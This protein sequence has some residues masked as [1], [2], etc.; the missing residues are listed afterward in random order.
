[1]KTLK[2]HHVSCTPITH[3]SLTITFPDVI[4]TGDGKLLDQHGDE[5][6]S[7]DYETGEIKFTKFPLVAC[8][9]LE[10]SVKVDE[11]AM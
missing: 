10:R 9:Y 7:V 3:G 6:G 11:E 5:V 2:T 4:D 1:M 8:S